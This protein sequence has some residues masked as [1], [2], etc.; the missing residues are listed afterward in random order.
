MPLA[1]HQ[2]DEH[3]FPYFIYV[4]VLSEL[5]TFLYPWI[6]HTCINIRS[7]IIVARYK[8]SLAFHRN[9]RSTSDSQCVKKDTRSNEI[10]QT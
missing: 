2:L 5:Y 10:R 8:I 9:Y 3:N 4:L 6:F 1:I 7:L